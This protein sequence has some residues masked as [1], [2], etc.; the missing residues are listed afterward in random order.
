MPTAEDIMTR[1]IVAIRPETTL[2]Q[3][4]DMILKNRISGMPVTDSDGRLLGVITE[5]AL[6]AIA[7]D[8]EVRT[9][10]VSEYMTRN[11]IS[12]AEDEPIAKI[13]DLC[14]LH[15]I[16]RVPVVSQER[17][18]GLISRRDLLQAASDAG[19]TLCDLRP[20]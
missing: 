2:Q 7:Y 14:I 11:V 4:T 13:A 16:R 3:A 6:L 8:P 12:V 1:D 5:F 20:R 19:G 18:V 15:R 9:A 10:P 17:L